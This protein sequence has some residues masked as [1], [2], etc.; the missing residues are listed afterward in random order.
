VSAAITYTRR[1]LLLRVQRAVALAWLQ[2]EI[3]SAEQWIAACSRDGITDGEQ[4]RHQRLAVEA[5]R[6]RRALWEAA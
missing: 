3:T 1:P 5:L 2:Y 6:V 4:L